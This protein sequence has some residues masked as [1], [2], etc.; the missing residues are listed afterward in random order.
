MKHILTSVLV[1]L[2]GSLNSPASCQVRN[3]NLDN[4]I[5]KL[6]LFTS[7]H[8]PEKVYLQFD[9]PY[10]AAGDTIYLKAYVTKGEEHQLS[11]ISSVLHVDLINPQNKVDQ[12]IK[13]QLDSGIAWA[14]FVLPDSLPQGNYRVRAYTN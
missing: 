3:E 11:D 1:F 2:F 14:N 4:L 9:K 10:Y 7:L 5:S 12:F 6:K 8:I 13:L